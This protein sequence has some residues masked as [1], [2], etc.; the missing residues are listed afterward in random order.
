MNYI[1]NRIEKHIRDSAQ[2]ENR[3]RLLNGLSGIALFYKYLYNDN[4]EREY[5]AKLISI[6]LRINSL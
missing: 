2:S 4:L 1:I 5:Q 3:I 6:I